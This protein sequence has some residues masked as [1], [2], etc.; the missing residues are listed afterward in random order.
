MFLNIEEGDLLFIN[1][2]PKNFFQASYISVANV[3]FAFPPKKQE[4]FS[5]VSAGAFTATKR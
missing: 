4:V 2:C 3:L 1:F 5:L